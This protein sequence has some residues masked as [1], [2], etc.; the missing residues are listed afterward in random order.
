MF[1]FYAEIV[2]EEGGGIRKIGKTY[3]C[4]VISFTYNA[5][6][7]LYSKCLQYSLTYYY[8]Q[9]IALMSPNLLDYEGFCY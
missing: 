6:N 3:S 4:S 9:F 7:V 8:Q 1:D 2:S 5:F